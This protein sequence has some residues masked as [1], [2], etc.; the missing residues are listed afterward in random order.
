[1]ACFL[2]LSCLLGFAFLVWLV[3]ELVVRGDRRDD[4]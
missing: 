3:G 4:H 1:M 2:A